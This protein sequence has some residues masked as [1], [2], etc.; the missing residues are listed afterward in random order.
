MYMQH[1]FYSVM[2]CIPQ[3]T[4]HLVGFL[5]PLRSCLLSSQPQHH[6]RTHPHPLTPS[7]TTNS[8]PN[9]PQVSRSTVDQHKLR[10]DQKRVHHLPFL[11]LYHPRVQALLDQ[12]QGAPRHYPR[13]L[14]LIVQSFEALWINASSRRISLGISLSSF[15]LFPVCGLHCLHWSSRVHL[16]HNGFDPPNST[17]RLDLS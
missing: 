17:L 14:S 8:G 16:F 7:P 10:D 15:S 11:H 6:S 9:G 1:K 12:G 4:S 2:H 5:T 3:T 13:G